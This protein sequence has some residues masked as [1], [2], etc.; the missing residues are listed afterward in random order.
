MLKK[1]VLVFASG[2]AKDGGSGFQELVEFSRTNPPILEAEIVG[3]V[4]NHERGGVR[5]KADVLRIPFSFWP[6]PFDVQ[7]Y[8]KYVSEFKVDF[9]M[10]SGWLKIVRGLDPAKTINIHPAPLPE[11]GGKG[12]YGRRV[13]ETIIAAYKNGRVSQSAVTMHFIDDSYDNGPIIFKIPVLIRPDDNAETLATRVNEKERAWQSFVLNLVIR[14]DI[15]L[16]KNK[17]VRTNGAENLPL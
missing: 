14:G 3:V 9:V 1:R 13:H 7:G 2:N 16:E 10:C 8:Q 4:S 11:F 15:R 6:G 12:L 5:K 17:V